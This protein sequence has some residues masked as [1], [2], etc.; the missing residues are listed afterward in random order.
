MRVRIESFGFAFEEVS[1]GGQGHIVELS[2]Q[3]PTSLESLLKREL[4]LEISDKVVL[5][6]GS[7]VAPNYLTQDGD[8][9]QIV[10]FMEGG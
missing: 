8:L 4:H 7:H 5:V 3:S 10:R 6:N 9:V 2:V 1:P